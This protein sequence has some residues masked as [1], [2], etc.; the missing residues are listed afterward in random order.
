MER[1]F[2]IGIVI[3]LVVEDLLL[4]K[5]YLG[6]YV[7]FFCC[8]VEVISLRIVKRNIRMCFLILFLERL[9]LILRFFVMGEIFCFFEF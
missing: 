3:E 7:N 1:V 6:V 4:F 5:Y 9:V 8:F 2:Y